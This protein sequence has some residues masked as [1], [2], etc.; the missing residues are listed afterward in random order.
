VFDVGDG[1]KQNRAFFKEMREGMEADDGA[2][3]R[4]LLRYLLDFDLASIDVNE[5][6]N[7][8]AL[9]DQK[10]RSLDPFYQWWFGCLVEGR[11]L[12][13]GFGD[14]WPAEVETERL[15]R[16]LSVHLKDRNIHSRTPAP[17]QIGRMLKT[18]AQ[19]TRRRARRDGERAYVYPFGT[20]NDCRVAWEKYI[21]GTVEWDDEDAQ[22]SQVCK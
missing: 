13:E 14:E 3:Y 4:L 12:G 8:Q 18:C 10:H 1:K 22:V 17:E 2:G 20:L 16:A 11:I 21:G 19:T 15:R 5:A 9:L 6:P 7:T